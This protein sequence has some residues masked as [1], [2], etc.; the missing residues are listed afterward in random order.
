M[1]TG[2][3]AIYNN[4]VDNTVQGIVAGGSCDQ[5][6]SFAFPDDATNNFP[7]MAQDDDTHN[8]ADRDFEFRIM[9]YDGTYLGAANLW[10]SNQGEGATPSD[11][12]VEIESMYMYPMIDSYSWANGIPPFNYH[13]YPK[14]M[15]LTNDGTPLGIPWSGDFIV[16]RGRT[17][18]DCGHC[19]AGYNRAEIHPPSAMAWVHRTASRAG[20]VWLRAFSHRPYPGDQSV[21]TLVTSPFTATFYIPDGPNGQDPYFGPVQSDFL[22]DPAQQ[23]VFIYRRP[24]GLNQDHP[25]ACLTNVNGN[26]IPSALINAE[27]G[28]WFG[29]QFNVTATPSS[30]G[31]QTTVT[32]QARNDTGYSNVPY[33]MGAHYQVCYPE[34][35]ATGHV[36]NG[37]GGHCK[38]TSNASCPAGQGCDST[39]RCSPVPV[40]PR[41]LFIDNL[42]LSTTQIGLYWSWGANDNTAGYRVY[43]NTSLI[44][45]LNTANGQQGPPTSY[46]DNGVSYPNS[47]TYYLTG[48]SAAGVTGPPSASVTGTPN[49]PGCRASSC[50]G[51]CN[52]QGQCDP[53]GADTS[54]PAGGIQGGACVDCTASGQ[55]CT[56]NFWNSGCG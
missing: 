7:R 43:R 1:S 23:G 55:M 48:V 9:P 50:Y 8:H 42:G 34:C 20:T 30:D 4:S 2:W 36:T 11:I 24:Q 13:F 17:A 5:S 31:M 47:Y 40:A 52:A 29:Y 41:D 32:I 14:G 26:C 54:C 6:R 22:V 18:W 27:R 39:G 45:T 10:G 3:D 51:C 49:A 12:N 56:W 37:C 28:N 25:W 46:V 44:A 21:P 19:D 33:I 38:C 53:S 15:P 35:D 16:V